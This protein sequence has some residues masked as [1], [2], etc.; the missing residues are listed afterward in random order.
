MSESPRLSLALSLALALTP[1]SMC[2]GAAAGE[3]PSP[4]PSAPPLPTPVIEITRVWTKT[5]PA[6]ASEPL[7]SDAETQT[8]EQLGRLVYSRIDVELDEVTLHD[9]FRAL[10]RELGLNMIVFEIDPRGRSN[11]PGIDGEQLVQLGLKGVTGR[12]LLEALCAQAGKGVTWQ[13]RAG[14]IEVGP[15][16]HLAREEACE[17]RSYYTADLAIDPPD[18]KSEGIGTLGIQSYNRRD[19]DEN[20][21]EL[22]RMIVTQC[23]PE[24]FEPAPPR[25]VE[26]S[27]GRVVPVQHTTPPEPPKKGARDDS[28]GRKSPNTKATANFDPELAQIFVNGQWASIQAKDNNLMIHAPDF[29]HRAIGGYPRPIPPPA[30]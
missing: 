18:Y 11:R 30:D 26:D 15:K 23:E 2:V 6:D 4:R 10:R 8:R 13:I 22:V 29:V 12:A 21:G 25:T 19:S 24:A 3:P 28:T 5:R 20:I 1:A 17:T 14:I 27:S 9:A 16:A 7:P